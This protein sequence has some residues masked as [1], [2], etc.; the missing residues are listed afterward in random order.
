MGPIKEGI[1]QSVAKGAAISKRKKAVYN[2]PGCNYM[3]NSWHDMIN[4][5]LSLPAGDKCRKRCY[6]CTGCR[7]V[8]ETEHGRCKRT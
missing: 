6:A 5:H 2:C 7:F 1:A 4:T 3:A 8:S